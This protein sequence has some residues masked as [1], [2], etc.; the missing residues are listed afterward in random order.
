MSDVTFAELRKRLEEQTLIKQRGIQLNFA[1]QYYAETPSP[2]PAKLWAWVN[3]PRTLWVRKHPNGEYQAFLQS[4]HCILEGE[5]T[6][7]G[8]YGAI[9]RLARGGMI[10]WSRDAQ[11]N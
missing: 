10:N 3:G 7:R 9:R 11:R 8:L 6:R 2:E 4:A 1:R 5:R